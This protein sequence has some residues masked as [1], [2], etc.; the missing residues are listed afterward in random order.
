MTK[1]VRRHMPPPVAVAVEGVE[2][3]AGARP[4]VVALPPIE[5]ERHMAPF[6]EAMERA[7]SEDKRPRLA[8]AVAAYAPAARR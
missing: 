5:P 7:E 8:A 3:G 2:E 6:R 4:P 1:P